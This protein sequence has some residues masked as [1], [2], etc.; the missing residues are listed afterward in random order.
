MLSERRR[1]VLSA[2]VEEYISSAHPVGSRSLV[3]RYRLGCSPATVRNELAILEE[4]GYVFQ[5]H[6]S[7]GRVPTDSGYRSFVDELLASD[8]A[9][10]GAAPAGTLIRTAELDELMREASHLLT[11]LTSCMAVVLAPELSLVRIRRMDLLLMAPR[12]AL[13]VL[14]T[15]TGQVVNR[16]I[17]LPEETTPERLAEAERALNAAFTD[18]RS[19]EIRPMRAA[20]A[21]QEP[22]DSLLLKIVDEMLDCLAEADDDRLYH[23]GMPALLAQPEF[24]QADHLMPLMS[25]VED[26]IGMLEALSDVLADEGVAVRIGSENRKAEFGNVSIVAT[27]YGTSSTDGVVGVIGP[28]RMDYTKA[29]AAVRAVADGLNEALEP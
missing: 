7:A 18:K 29:I 12:R 26:G 28:T 21:T 22:V 13:F 8:T 17:E 5:P 14:I 24:A 10:P 6:V 20:M 2:L 11:R 27:H 25:A 9:A 16:S 4:T 15:E 19:A 1:R 23:G 3:E